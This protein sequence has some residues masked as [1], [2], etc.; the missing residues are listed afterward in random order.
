MEEH[1]L[2]A[3]SMGLDWFSVQ[4]HPSPS[5]QDAPTATQIR[6]MSPGQSE[7]SISQLRFLLPDD[8]GE[9]GVGNWTTQTSFRR[10]RML[11]TARKC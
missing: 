10:G 4:C 9:S 6:K 5:A 7:G 11:N 1:R 2:L 3:C 8:P